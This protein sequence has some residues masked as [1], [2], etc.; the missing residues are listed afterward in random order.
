M[1]TGVSVAV[2]VAR[3]V[4]VGTGVRV[5]DGVA[6]GVRVDTGVR[7]A[8][9]VRVAVGVA[10]GVRVGTGVRVAVGVARGVDVGTGVGAAVGVARGV[11]VGTGVGAV[12]PGVPSGTR[13]IVHASVATYAVSK[14]PVAVYEI[15]GADV[16][17]ATPAVSYLKD[18]VPRLTAGND[19]SAEFA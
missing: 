17:V 10:R 8:A 7:V 19:N 4:R 18:V 6:R 3:E 16:P 12:S 1:G 11:R 13:T 9:G 2:G 14:E 5:A 15:I